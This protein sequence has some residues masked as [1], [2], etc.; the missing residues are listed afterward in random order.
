[1][2]ITRR[3]FLFAPLAIGGLAVSACAV[4]PLAPLRLA[5]GSTLILVRHADRTDENLNAA[6]R[7]RAAA[8]PAALDGLALDLILSP[9]IQRNLDTAKPLA[10]ARGL[11]ITRLPQERPAARIVAL[12]AGKSAIWIG[13]KG[14]LQS[15]WD[16]LAPGG[17]PPLEYGDLF[18]LTADAEGRLLVDRRHWG[19]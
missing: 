8:L 9:G 13:N 7:A 2:Q 12:G 15:I 10:E 3:L 19:A 4:G 6:G 18:I 5:P 11:V 17:E 14:N 16:D 1:M